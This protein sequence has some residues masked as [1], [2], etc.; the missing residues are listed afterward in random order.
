LQ[1]K[2][3]FVQKMRVLRHTLHRRRMEGKFQQ[4]MPIT[5]ADQ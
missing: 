3:Q 4:S 1:G 2:A 5:T